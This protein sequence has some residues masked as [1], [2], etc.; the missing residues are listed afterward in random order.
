MNESGSSASGEQ[1]LLAKK[2]VTYK[3]AS[4]FLT[5]CKAKPERMRTLCSTKADRDGGEN[6]SVSVEVGPDGPT[7]EVREISMAEGWTGCRFSPASLW[8]ALEVARP[9]GVIAEGGKEGGSHRP[10]ALE[11]GCGVALAGL[12]A[13]SIGYD[14]TLTDC[15][16]GHL[17]SLEDR[18]CGQDETSTFKVRCL[19]WLED[20][21]SEAAASCGIDL[22]SPEN[23]ISA[24]PEWKRINSEELRSFDL[25]LASDVVYEEHHAM[26]LPLVI[27]R[28]LKPG[29]T[30]VLAL[31]IRDEGMFC[32]LLEKL[33]SVGLLQADV[34]WETACVFSKCEF[35]SSQDISENKTAN[36][37]KRPTSSKEVLERLQE[38]IIGHEGG[39]FLL[40]GQRPMS[41]D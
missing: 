37:S 12:S 34:F 23:V 9:D 27:K 38:V 25:V 31:A 7:V 40:R 29:G 36:P 35:C 26:L 1:K 18:A 3:E 16:V 4:T 28:W 5:R 17:K 41:T 22:G 10:K 20:V 39:A 19:D 33:H 30:F 24:G 6:L 13:H 2:H 11:L 14:T 15:L 32:R 8:L 21:G